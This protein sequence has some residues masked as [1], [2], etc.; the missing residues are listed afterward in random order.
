M[1]VYVYMYPCGMYVYLYV[2]MHA[3]I[4]ACMCVCR[5]VHVCRQWLAY[6]QPY[7]KCSC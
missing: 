2:C 5:H 6:W 3:S 4:L 1:R 7:A